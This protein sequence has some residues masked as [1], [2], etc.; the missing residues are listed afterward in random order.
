VN[1]FSIS[2]PAINARRLWW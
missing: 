2:F 1:S